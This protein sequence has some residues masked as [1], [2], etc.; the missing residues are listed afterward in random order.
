MTTKQLKT[1]FKIMQDFNINFYEEDIQSQKH[2]QQT[3]QQEIAYQNQNE[4]SPHTRYN[5]YY[6]NNIK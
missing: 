5:V 4:T 3:H 1:Q 2:A 6:K